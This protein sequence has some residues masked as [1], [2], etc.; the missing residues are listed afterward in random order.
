MR[1]G[2]ISKQ[3]SGFVGNNPKITRGLSA[4]FRNLL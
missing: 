3:F 1:K 4:T 2:E